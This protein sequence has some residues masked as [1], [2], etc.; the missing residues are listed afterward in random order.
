MN[1]KNYYNNVVE[2]IEELEVN[3]KLREIKD[4][5]ETLFTYW[6]IGKSIVEAQ[7]GNVRAKYGDNLIKRWGEKLA[8]TYG[9]NYSKANLFR[10]KQFYLTFSNIAT[11]WR[12]LNWSQCKL[13]LPIKKKM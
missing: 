8:K 9:K 3:K 7:G 4:N 12:H 5:R 13:L 6:N 11:M 1:E 2:L 10:Y